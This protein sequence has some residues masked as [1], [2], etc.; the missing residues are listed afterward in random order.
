MSALLETR[1]LEARYGD[2]QALFGIDLTLGQGETVAIIG[3]N[4]AGKSTL[5]R[6]ICGLNAAAPDQVRH[7]G[8]AI[9]GAAPEQIVARGIAMVP[10]VG[11]SAPDMTLMRLD[12]PAPLSPQI[13]TT[14]FS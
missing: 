4:G 9:G 7:R 10:E 8:Q 11:S 6:S 14:S 3:A 2:F 5:L 12:L 13:A 1:A